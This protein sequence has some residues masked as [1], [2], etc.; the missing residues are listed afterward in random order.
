MHTEVLEEIICYH[1][2]E[3]CAETPIIH[4]EKNF[5]CQGCKQVFEL[6]NENHL[7]DYYNCDLNP[8]ISP[9]NKNYEFLNNP[10]RQNYFKT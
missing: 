5:C 10:I 6:L 4:Q 9:T 2:G 1:C 8:G 3:E 7:E